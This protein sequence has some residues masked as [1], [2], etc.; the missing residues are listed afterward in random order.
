MYFVITWVSFTQVS[1][2]FCL[3]EAFLCNF[4][5][6]FLF[7]HFLEQRGFALR[8]K[9]ENA[10]VALIP[11]R[12]GS[13]G[14]VDKNIKPL[15]GR[16][17]IEWSIAA[18]LRT[19]LINRTIVSTD[20]LQYAEIAKNAG[21]EVPFLRP[22]KISND[23]STDYEFIAHAIDFLSQSGCH[24]EFIAH[25]RPTTPFRNPKIIDQAI[26]V[27]LSNCEATSLRSVQEMS[28]SAYKTFEISSSNYLKP[29]CSQG[30]E[31]DVAN[32]ARQD[33]PKT[34]AANGYIDLLSVDYIRS[35]GKIHGERSVPF[36]TPA[37]NELDTEYDFKLLESELAHQTPIYSQLF[38]EDLDHGV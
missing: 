37:V 29:I 11:A 12:S 28:E 38:G 10:V 16:P 31:V 32:L 8:F 21:A 19:E 20:S 6:F 17:L 36:K 7:C 5:F 14:V 25:I 1:E 18:S 9:N 22:Q 3:N 15:G 2:N 4:R 24:V 23:R 26:D 33:F 13:K 27:F 34:Y 30:D 35:T